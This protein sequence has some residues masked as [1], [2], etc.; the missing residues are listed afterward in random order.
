MDC[1]LKIIFYL[2]KTDGIR[3]TERIASMSNSLHSSL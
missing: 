1:S 2:L 3:I